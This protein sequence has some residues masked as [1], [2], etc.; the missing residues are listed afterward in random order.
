M[1]K[2]FSGIVILLFMA[3]A[4]YCQEPK[5]A[6]QQFDKSSP[7]TLTIKS[8]KQ[9]YEAGEKIRLSLEIKNLGSEEIETPSLVWSAK[10]ILDGKE[11]QRNYRNPVGLF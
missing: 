8:D 4:G 10:I 2:I 1:S 9:V 5:Q 11:R 7:L 6:L 3:T